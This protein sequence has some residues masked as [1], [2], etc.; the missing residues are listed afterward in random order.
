M[1]LGTDEYGGP[2]R[3]P[4]DTHAKVAVLDRQLDAADQLIATLKAEL[5]TTPDG[6]PAAEPVSFADLKGDDRIEAMR[7]EIDAGVAALGSADAWGRFLAANSRFHN[8]SL[9]NVMLILAQRPD[10]TRVAS[11]KKWKEFGRAPVKGSKAIWIN[12]PVTRKVIE[13]DPKTG[14]EKEVRRIVGV[15]PVPVF[16]VAQTDGDALPAPPQSVI[17]LDGRAPDGMTEA[18]A[19]QIQGKGFTVEY[20]DT[21]KAGGYTDFANNKVVI[22][23]RSTHMQQAKTLAH[24]LAHIELGHGE[25]SSEYHSNPGGARPDMEVEAESTA[26]V[27]TR[28]FGADSGDYSFGYIDSWAKGDTDRVKSTADNVVKAC[29]SIIGRLTGDDQ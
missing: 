20:G 23:D 26:Y 5:G 7:A 11:F 18:I 24:E 1:C 3:C 10:A 17:T 15:R 9:G 6:G 16:D 4:G 21:G 19:G 14:A 25:R 22:S 28:H 13:K 12:A 2:R 27:L 8:Y 29:K